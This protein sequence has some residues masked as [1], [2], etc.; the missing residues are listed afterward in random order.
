[1]DEWEA[2]MELICRH[3]A[4]QNV[5]SLSGVPSWMLVFIKKILENTGKHS[6]TE[7]WPNLE[8]FFHGGIS[9]TPYEQQYQAL[10]PSPRMRYLETYNASE[11]FFA[12]QDDLHDRSM[13][14]LL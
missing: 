3:T 1:M 2:K 4:E 8:V 11:G 5:T 6:L 14:L 13:Q 7:I 12:V 10:I 9:F